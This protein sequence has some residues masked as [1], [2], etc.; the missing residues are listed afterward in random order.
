[1]AIHLDDGLFAQLQSATDDAARIV[2][3][4]DLNVEELERYRD[5]AG[6]L[7]DE[8]PLFEALLAAAKLNASSDAPDEDESP[9]GAQA[10]ALY[11]TILAN[12]DGRSRYRKQI[13]SRGLFA[14]VHLNVFPF[15]PG[16]DPETFCS[17]ERFPAMR[18]A[19][20]DAVFNFLWV[21]SITG[22]AIPDVFLP[23]IKEGIREVLSKGVK[24]SYPIHD[25]GV[26]LRFGK[27][28]PVDS[29]EEAFRVAARTAFAEAVRKASPCLMEPIIQV[30]ARVPVEMAD[31]VI[32]QAQAHGNR[33]IGKSPDDELLTVQLEMAQRQLSAALEYVAK[34]GGVVQMARKIVR[35]AAVPENEDEDESSHFRAQGI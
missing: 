2:R 32:E 26:N 8:V 31:R 22:G 19:D 20:Y 23:A 10:I 5:E 1:M 14:E 17:K 35:Y 15:L 34:L 27:H 29:S 28:H 4:L 33:V 24:S 6:L 30:D 18:E 21:D 13:G 7:D 25:I 3:I 9:S 16:T 11:E 12:A